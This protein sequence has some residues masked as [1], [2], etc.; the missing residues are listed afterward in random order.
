MARKAEIETGVEL[1]AMLKKEAI[2]LSNAEKYAKSAKP[3]DDIKSDSYESAILDRYRKEKCSLEELLIEMYLSEL[4][5][6]AVE[7]VSKKLWGSRISLS[8]I[9]ELVKQI[10]G[11][12]EEWNKRNIGGKFYPYVFLDEVLLRRN[13]LQDNDDITI[14]IAVGIDE[15]GFR[16]AL[17]A[18]IGEKDNPRKWLDF[19]S[20]LNNRGLDGVKLVVSSKCFDTAE[21]ASVFHD[22]KIQYSATSFYTAVL[23]LVPKTKRQRITKALK[24]IHYQES[25][26]SARQKAESIIMDLQQIQAFEAAELV[27]D[28]YTETLSYMQYPAP[29]WSKIKTAAIIGNLSKQIRR[30]TRIIGAALDENTALMLVSARLRFIATN[31]WKRVTYTSMTR[32]F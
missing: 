10:S 18:V 7:D 20:D 24:A 26:E 5:L 32:D 25:V 3:R 2:A 1:S 15:D 6:R 22:V 27:K 19:L 31:K 9:S 29:H 11:S 13:W 28:T 8:S 16:T 30:R 21:L 4:S 17:G 14:L 23:K 12:I